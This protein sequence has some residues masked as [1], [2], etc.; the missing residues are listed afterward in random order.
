MVFIIQKQ[1]DKVSG[2][3]A[4]DNRKKEF[5]YAAIKKTSSNMIAVLKE[6][7]MCDT[8]K[9]TRSVGL[10]LSSKMY[11]GMSGDLKKKTY[12]SQ[13]MNRLKEELQFI[14]IHPTSSNNINMPAAPGTCLFNFL[15]KIWVANL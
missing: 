9:S 7:E 8:R 3:N 10:H 5:S 11:L 4:G 6:R 2:D 12:L 13:Q 14:G 15:F 1:I